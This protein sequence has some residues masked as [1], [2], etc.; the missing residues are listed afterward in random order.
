MSFAEQDA[1]LL[2]PIKLDLRYSAFSSIVLDCT[3]Q[4][5]ITSNQT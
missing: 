2:I 4:S 1:K 5:V 3:V